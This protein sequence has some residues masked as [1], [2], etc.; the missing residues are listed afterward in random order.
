[1]HSTG[2]RRR[3]KPRSAQTNETRLWG[4]VPAFRARS[5][6]PLCF[7]CPQRLA[8]PATSGRCSWRA[9]PWRSPGLLSEVLKCTKREPWAGAA[10]CAATTPPRPAPCRLCRAT[11]AIISRFI[12]SARPGAATR[13][14]H[15]STWQQVL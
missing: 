13:R 2:R 14:V 1:M 6:L 4:S 7:V 11:P 12:P 10:C 9:T 3:L 15:P 8:A 5:S